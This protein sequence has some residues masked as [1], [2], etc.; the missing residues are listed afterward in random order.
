MDS[1]GGDTMLRRLLSVIAVLGLTIGALPLLAAPAQALQAPVA[2][3]SASLSTW[4]TNGIVWAS[5]SSKGLVFVGGTFTSIRPPGAAV[6]T[7]EVA[8]TNF[9]VFDG[10]TGA[11]TSC[12]PAFGGVD[13]AT[14]RALN[15]SPDGNTLY[16]G[17][18]FANAGSI[19]AGQLAAI[20]ISSC[21]PISSFKPQPSGVV[22]AIASTSSA[23][24]YG[25]GFVS[26]AGSDRFYAAA[27]SAVGTATPGALLPWAPTFDT[28]VN[29]VNLKPDNSV[30]VLGGN[31]NTVNG[32]ASR[33]LVA[34]DATGGAVVHAFTGGFVAPTSAVKKIAVD[35]TGFYTGNE[36]TGGGVFDGRI[37]VNWDYTQRWRDTCLGATQVVLIYKSIIYSG[38]H[39][40]DCSSMGE[41]PDG[42]RNHLLAESVN[43]PTLLSWFPNTDEGPP[44]AEDIG[45]RDMA[46]AQTTSGDYLWVVGEFLNVNGSPQQGLTRF[47]QGPDTVAPS[48][49]VPSVTSFHTGQARITWRASLDTDDSLL[50]YQ[51]FRD[52]S[53]T[54]LYTTTATSFFWTRRQMSFTD[55]GL[56]P[57]SAHTYRVSV[58]DGTNTTFT[59]WRSVTIASS[60]S[61]YPDRV[62]AD[63][64][65]SLW[66]FDEP[67]DVFM[68]DSSSNNFNGTLRGGATY[69]VSPG[70]IAGDPSRALTLSGNNSTIYTETRLPSPTTYSL[71][72]WFNTTT[73]VG[74]KL[75]GFGDKQTFQSS[76]YDKQIYMGNNGRL[77]FGVNSGGIQTLTTTKAYNDGQW[78][79]V[80]GTQGADGM[81]LYVDGVRIAR[82]TVTGNQN[83]NG[84]WRIGG[85]AING[86]WPNRPTSPFWAGSLDELAIYPSALSAATVA[87]HFA[88]AGGTPTGTPT[89]AY[90]SAVYNDNPFF[91]WRLG[92]ASGTTAADATGG[93][94]T[95]TYGNGITYSQTGAVAG[96]TN[97]S[98]RLSGNSNGLVR[99][100]ASLNAPSAYTEEM[101]FKTNTNSGGKL[102]GFGSSATG[103]SGTFDR[104]VYM[105]NDGRLVFGVGT[106][107]SK[108]T[109]LSAAAYND[110]NWHYLAATQG[111]S[112]MV[113]YVDGSAVASNAVSSNS[114]YG[115]YWRVGGDNL[116]GW[117]NVPSSSYIAATVDE[118]AVYNTALSS[119]QVA[120]HYSAGNLSV[121]DVSP[122]TAP[123]G[124]TTGVT[125]STVQLGWQA[126]A[127][128]RGVTGYDVYR[129]STSGFAPSAANKIG[130]TATPGYTD[131]TA[132]AGTAY[133]RVIAFDAASNRSAASAEVSALVLDV[134]PPTQPQGVSLSTTSTT[135]SLSWTAS[136]DD[137]GVVGYD[138]YRSTTNGFTP[139]PANKVATTATVGYVDGPLANGTYY[140]RVVA[141]DGAGNVSTASDQVSGV[142]ADVTPPTAPGAVTPS[143]AGTTVSLAWGAAT[144]DVGVTGYNV[145][146]SATSG[147]AASPGNLVTTVAG[148]TASN[149][150]VPEGTWYYLV[151][152][153]DAA[154]NIGP[155]S[156]EVSATVAPQPATITVSPT[157]DTYANQGAPTTNYGTMS[158]L[159]SRGNPAAI[160]YLRMVLPPAPAGKALTSA[161]LRIRTSTDASAG[162]VEQHTV[163]TAVD[164][165]DE[166]TLTWNNHPAITGPLLGTIAG[167]TVPNTSYDTALDPSALSALLGTQISLS[168]TDAGTDGLF[169]WSQNFS[170][171]SSRPQLILTF[172]PVDSTP[173][174]APGGAAAGV[175]GSSVSLSWTASTDNTGV[176]G[177]DV[178]RS[179]VSGFVPS[180]G[181]LVGSASG[182]G[183]T[184]LGVPVGTWY[185]LVVAKDAAGNRSASSSEVSAVVL[186]PA[187]PT[188]VGTSVSGS[189][190]SVSWTGSSGGTPATGYRVYRS[191]TS[192]FVPSPSTLVGSTATTAYSD[193][194]VPVGTWYYVVVATDAAA[195]ASAPSAE[196]S[197][198][199]LPPGAPTGV[200]TGVSGSTVTVSW[201][202]SSGGTPATGY[203]VYRSDT[204]GFVPGPSTLLG[205]TAATTY[206]DSSV[207]VGTWYY[208]VV[209]TDAAADVSAP[210]AEASAAVVPPPPDT[211]PPTPP[212]STSTSVSGSSVTVS[213]TAATDDT[214]VTG[215][216]VYRSSTS[217][218]T[219]SGATLVGSTSSTSFGDTSV[220]VGTWYYVVIAGDAAGNHS[221]PSAQT[222]AVVLPPPDTTAPSAPT[223]VSGSA[224]GHAVTV[225]WTA[226]T[227]DTAVTG[228]DVYRGTSA[229]F[230]ANS[231]SKVG[232]TAGTTFNDPSVATG[233]VFYKVIAFDAATNR[234]DASAASAAVVVPDVD[235]PT[236]PT[237][238]AV[239]A[240]GTTANAVWNASSD[241]VG[242][243]GYDVY[244]S[245]TSGFTPDGSTKVGTTATTSF[246]DPSLPSGTYYYR[247]IAFD[248]ASNRSSASTQAAVAV[249]LTPT[250]VVLSPTADT[251]ANQGAATTNYGTAGSLASRGTTGYTAYL[252]FPLP[253]APAG[254][255][256]TGAV[257]QF[258]TTTDS[259][260]GSSE[261]QSVDLANNS[262]VES[263]LTWNN[264]PALGSVVG[265]IGAGTVP[266]AV[267]Q[268]AL[269]PAQL[270]PLTGADATLAV[271][272]TGT[273][274]LWFWSSNQP[275]V[276]YRPTLTL[277]YSAPPPV[278]MAA[279]AFSL[280][281]LSTSAKTSASKTA[282]HP[283]ALSWCV[284]GPRGCDFS[285]SVKQVRSHVPAH[286]AKKPIKAK[287]VLRQ[288]KSRPALGG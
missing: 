137:V 116:S 19:S 52:N 22:R 142:V 277:T 130:T 51:V 18:F 205:S 164:T 194:S 15:V 106:G 281:T 121:P 128:N 276:S 139:A 199:V 207:A 124:V 109:L 216:D 219:P 143:V 280:S 235:A 239:T 193:T 209:A 154:G 250:V 81:N 215:Y 27:A 63:G 36:G 282:T 183:F 273:D 256:L 54:A 288:V 77:V 138:I 218:F 133:Y 227:D 12:A 263:T 268:T 84:Y 57:G 112:G 189:T 125:G 14:V 94:I 172:S 129:S 28:E 47:G 244:R 65:S 202:A 46:L 162:S 148:L 141:R 117:P 99:S 11:P 232:T 59:P 144:D 4:Q 211:T 10:A 279:T 271:T 149:T 123:T 191:A 119:Q 100:T 171:A 163:R 7:G 217:G 185:Y 222:S 220:P 224:V 97:T 134:S 26:V 45:P 61:T 30:V 102:I 1:T 230:T 258:R 247:V 212:T 24:Y 34:V 153:R 72:T 160:S 58:S 249:A 267:Y 67:A 195:D 32:T 233:T 147:F 2:F 75:V 136:T 165:W 41:F 135:A 88:L 53:T 40:H 264:R 126:S 241:N 62:L 266:N 214:G 132:P 120:G 21:T 39:G 93:G 179:A 254:K 255:V 285:R 248:A 127:D 38:S 91:Q 98:V 23:V 104:N 145:Y 43:D 204:S 29:A 87:A 186:P 9:A 213:W 168:V 33:A 196:A 107:S 166:L 92:E 236:T 44:G 175:S 223:G 177:Y 159:N 208:V 287:V 275:T 173:P 85:D 70:A 68:S 231:S 260:A 56:A 246:S 170:T 238:L 16:V 187:A 201:T 155:V 48:Y 286:H 35:A 192:G 105:R 262:W 178:Y 229:G 146:R 101:W 25:G 245:T 269:D 253:A 261:P 3:T 5:A 103:N 114:S 161:V 83:I 82:N 69:Q 86:S 150:G 37:A 251:Y 265:T 240:S 80:V 274:N 50:T 242:V 157:A 131:S 272:E 210:S 108:T 228:Y 71:E 169:F 203:N 20:D 188:A 226:S 118:V 200:G 278:M 140:Y 283:P 190:V 13:G 252:R 60:N 78:H 176:T 234:S 197:A 243:T 167:G 174:S 17:G 90:G 49:A 95:G 64:A 113:L 198:V 158:S 73:T 237:G 206:V 110:N 79:Q 180:G 181:T 96:T 76:N 89:D 184:D 74:G 257:L 152:A 225:T 182:T 115:G 31:F 259:F 221:D 270:S 66:R 111:A 284:H 122:P 8:R 6:G 151:A 55:T 156:A 42:N